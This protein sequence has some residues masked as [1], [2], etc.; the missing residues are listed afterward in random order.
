MD[1]L[2]GMEEEEYEDQIERMIIENGVMLRGLA[3]LLVRK[4]VVSQEE[5]DEE[6]DRLYEEIEEYD[7]EDERE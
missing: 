1:E 6:L 7:D 4:G 2:N 3:N 5:L